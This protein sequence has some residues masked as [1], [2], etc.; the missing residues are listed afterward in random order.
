L[1]EGKGERL[2]FETKKVPGLC[3]VLPEIDSGSRCGSGKGL[4][5]FVTLRQSCMDL[6]KENELFMSFAE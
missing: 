5:V 2:Q 4:E 6:L 3:T 1:A